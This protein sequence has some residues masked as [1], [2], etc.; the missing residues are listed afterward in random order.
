MY[1]LPF[2]S[3]ASLVAVGLG[4]GA[5]ASGHDVDSHGRNDS[6]GLSAG[7]DTAADSFGSSGVGDGNTTG[8]DPD[9]ASESGT[10]DTSGP[11]DPEPTTTTGGHDADDGT[12]S[13]STDGQAETTGTPEGTSTGP[14][15]EETGGEPLIDASGWVVHQTDSERTFTLPPGTLVPSGG[16]IVIA[17]GVDIAAFE[18]F[19]GVTLGASV[20]FL[21]AQGEFPTING[22]ETYT[23][24]SPGRSPFD[25]PTEPLALGANLQR[26]DPDGA[27]S[28]SWQQQIA[29]MQV[30]SPG[31][32]PVWDAL[33]SGVYLSEVSD[34]PGAGTYA[35]EFIELRVY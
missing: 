30:A 32:G 22:D 16:W 15:G 28:G 21:D 35:H 31:D 7:E 2:I 1:A 14:W 5:C 27:Q 26:S 12:S 13:G 33:P 18:A 24:M 29:T 9:D 17:R 20:V 3:A 6:I 34:A 23:V 11:V 4:L 25:G 10:S 19:W 8:V